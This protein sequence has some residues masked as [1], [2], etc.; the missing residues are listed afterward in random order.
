V[1]IIVNT[2]FT[3]LIDRRKEPIRWA[4]TLQTYMH[5]VSESRMAAERGDVPVAKFCG[6]ISEEIH[7]TLW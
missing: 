2:D 1:G 3:K 6:K 7:E 4:M 5:W